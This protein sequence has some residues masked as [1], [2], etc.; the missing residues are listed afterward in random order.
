MAK[1]S[2]NIIVIGAGASGIM[3]AGIA[4]GQGGSVKLLEK[5]P[6]Y[7]RKLSMTGNGRCNITNIAPITEFPRHYHSSFRF[8][9]H[10][11]HSFTNQDCIAFFE[12]L[13]IAFGEE[14][15]GRVLPVN[16]NGHEIS[17]AF[18][19]WA[20]RCGVKIVPNISVTKILVI[21]NKTIG[22]EAK[23]FDGNIA[24]IKADAV[25]IATGGKSYPKTGSTGDGYELAKSVGHTIIPLRP[26]LVPLET[27]GDLSKRLQGVSLPHVSVTLWVDNHK[28]TAQIGDMIFTHYGVSGPL[29]LNL[30]RIAV[31][32]K[33]VQKDVSISIDLVPNIDYQILF[34][35][36]LGYIKNHNKQQFK[37]MLTIYLPKKMISVCCEE[38]NITGDKM[39]NQISNNELKRLRVWLKSLTL[40]VTGH[41]SFDEAMI[42]AGGV[43][44]NQVNPKTLESKIIKGLHFA[45]EVLDIDAET[46]GFNLQAAFSTGWL[47]GNACLMDISND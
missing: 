34:K 35:E 1:T 12:G 19:K 41:R 30:S 27:Q 6:V 8:L 38:I 26:A 23:D 44:T 3:A 40:K 13:G 4:A 37:N 20:E 18:A 39:L 33:I 5:T 29:I 22:I 14:D 31:D 42:T 17:V 45:G 28:E 9:R 21:N 36:F 47:A 11:L 46:G 7:G 43:D 2:S 32:S 24:Q 16:S 25:I 15:N 10:A